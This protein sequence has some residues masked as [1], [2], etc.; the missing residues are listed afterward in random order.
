MKPELGEAEDGGPRQ[1]AKI[2]SEVF[3]TRLL[4]TK[5]RWYGS[6]ACGK[7]VAKIICRNFSTVDRE[8]F[9]VKIFSSIHRA[10]KIKCMK[11]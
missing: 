9:T 5:V 10:A 4:S 11:N 3:L 6:V 1:G 7:F 8:I 2:M